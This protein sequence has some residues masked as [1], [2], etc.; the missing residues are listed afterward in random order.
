ME[1]NKSVKRTWLYGNVKSD[2]NLYTSI[3]C[4]F[5]KLEND[6]N[7]AQMSTLFSQI[8]QKEIVFTIKGWVSRTEETT[9]SDRKSGHW[10]ATGHEHSHIQGEPETGLQL[11]K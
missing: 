4:I 9:K 2:M 3:H 6:G 8:F 7:L 11:S 5:E 10:G 1:E